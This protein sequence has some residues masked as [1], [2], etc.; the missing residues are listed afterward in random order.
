MGDKV[1][2]MRPLN[3]GWRTDSGITVRGRYSGTTMCAPPKYSI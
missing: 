3:G 1:Y 2:P